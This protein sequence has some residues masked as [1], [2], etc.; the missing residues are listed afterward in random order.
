MTNIDIT[1][2]IRHRLLAELNRT[3]ADLL[4]KE[5]FGSIQELLELQKRYQDMIN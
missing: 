3:I 5:Q 4:A 1:R 2:T